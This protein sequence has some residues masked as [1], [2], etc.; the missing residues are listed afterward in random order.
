MYINYYMARKSVYPSVLFGYFLVGILPYGPFLWNI[1]PIPYRYSLLQLVSQQR[2]VR[3]L[4]AQL[5]LNVKFRLVLKVSIDLQGC[6]PENSVQ[7]RD[8]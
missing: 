7:S 4:E 1:T 3:V 6:L 8:F 2:E 5:A